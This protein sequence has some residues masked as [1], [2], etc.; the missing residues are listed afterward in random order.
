METSIVDSD[1]I[2]MEGQH[3]ETRGRMFKHTLYGRMTCIVGDS[4]YSPLFL[5][6]DKNSVNLLRLSRKTSV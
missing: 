1:L 3:G 2:A 5:S 4:W 6:V